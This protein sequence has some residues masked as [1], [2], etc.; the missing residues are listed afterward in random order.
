MLIA[1]HRDVESPDGV[2]ERWAK[3]LTTRGV[4]IRWIDLT[5]PE[6]LH[7]VRN[8]DGVMWHWSQVHKGR[9]IC[10]NL[11]VIEFQLRI[12][13]F[14]NHVSSWHRRD[15]LAQYYL[16]EAAGVPMPKTWIFWDKQQAREW[17][18]QTDY[19][20][21]FKLSSG[22]GGKGVV[23]VRSVKEA[24]HLIDRMF[25]PGLSSGQID[26]HLAGE[27]SR[28]WLAP[29]TLMSRCKAAARFVALGK[30]PSSSVEKGYVYFQDFVPGNDYKTGIIVIGNKAF[31]FLRFNERN[32]FRSYGVS[33]HHNLPPIDLSSAA[34]STDGR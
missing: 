31:G 30:P 16:L 7:Q 32:D 34:Q 22:G 6:A 21:V 23:L 13:V 33:S 3:G 2:A 14:P 27:I 11:H 15:K 26:Q 25:G 5:A 9:R 17:A 10:R 24:N 29:R 1:I 8:C 4:D 18:L 20:K 19:P 12:P 28:F